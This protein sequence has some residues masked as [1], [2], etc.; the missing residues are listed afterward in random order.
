MKLKSS[1]Y[2]G[3]VVHERLRP[4]RHSLDYNVFSV[5]LDLSETSDLN[6]GFRL[7]SFNRWGVFSFYEKD[8]GPLTGECLSSWVTMQL[9]N[10]K[11]YFD[12]LN[13]KLLCYP[14]ILGYV[15]NPLSVYFCYDGE[16]GLIAILYEVC[17]TFGERHTYV[18]PVTNAREKIIKQ[19]CRKLH[20]VS[21]FIGMDANYRFEISP[22]TDEVKII[23]KEDDDEGLFLIASFI[24]KSATFNKVNLFKCLLYYPM[25]SIKIMGGIHLE[26]IKLWLKGFRYYPHKPVSSQVIVSNI[27]SNSKENKT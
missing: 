19:E 10:S 18:L 15:F 2:K 6:I 17:N 16:K 7:F 4:K 8:H 11:I 24:G 13:I 3:T 27:N 1:I 25:Q 5:L 12:T 26:A 22:P 20:Y 14:R 23:I 9:N 21:P